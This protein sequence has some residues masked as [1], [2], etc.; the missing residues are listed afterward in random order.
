MTSIEK[1]TGMHDLGGQDGWGA[2]APPDADEKVF[3]DPWEARAFALALLSMRLSGTNLDAFRHAMNRLDRPEYFDDGYYGRWLHGAENLLKDSNII[4]PDAVDARARKLAGVEVDEPE[5][6]EPAKPDYAPTA[7]GSLR[8]VDAPQRFQV[9]D[10]VRAKVTE[11]QGH[12]RL[13]RY[14]MGHEGRVALV[15][16]AQLLPDTHA[17][18]LGEN[19]QWVYAVTF[20]SRELFGVDGEKF[21]LTIDLYDDYLEPVA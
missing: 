9:G 10:R 3:K 1:A 4:A 8:P 15:N 7:A 17:H 11:P 19:P 12:T 13:P 14:V 18:F 16:P 20:D 21:D 5:A 2:V 6:P